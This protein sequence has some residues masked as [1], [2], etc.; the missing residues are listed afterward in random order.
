M[1][2]S[3]LLAIVNVNTVRF[4]G[5]VCGEV[6]ETDLSVNPPE[7]YGRGLRNLWLK[8]PPGEFAAGESCAPLLY[9]IGTKNTA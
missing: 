1:L 4:R 9:K 3:N 7:T 6:Y 5:K 2:T 8:K